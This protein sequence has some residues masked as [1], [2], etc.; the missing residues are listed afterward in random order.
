MTLVTSV[1]V[2][3]G[4]KKTRVTFLGSTE[5]TARLLA[6]VASRTKQHKDKHDRET[7]SQED[8]E[9]VKTLL[10]ALD[11]FVNRRQRA[12]KFLKTVA[13]TSIFPGI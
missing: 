4:L 8:I 9:T 10:E 2:S 13:N 5:V 11:V 3:V 6:E 12:V 7:C 1:N